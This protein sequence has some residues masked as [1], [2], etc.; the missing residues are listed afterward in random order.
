MGKVAESTLEQVEHD[1][2]GGITSA[3]LLSFFEAQDVRFGEATLRKW[4]QLGLLPRSVRV[5]RKGK[6][7]GSQGKYPVRVVRQILRI[8]E[9]MERDLTIEDIQK[10]VLFVRGDIEDLETTLGKVFRALDRNVDRRTASDA[11]VALPGLRAVKADIGRARALADDLLA[12]LE[13]IEER[14][15]S[16]PDGAAVEEA[17][18]S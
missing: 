14:L 4:V 6:H 1:H 18:A 5:G 7:Q 8:K 16:D 15:V 12:R 10:Q 3:D 9:L 2:S 11:K 13:K 17:V